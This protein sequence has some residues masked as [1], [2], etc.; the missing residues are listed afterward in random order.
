[1][2]KCFSELSDEELNF[3][4]RFLLNSGSLKEMAK[5]YEVSYP[6]LRLR[7]NRLIEKIEAIEKPEENDP[8]RLK[9]KNLAAEGEI[10]L[11]TAKKILSEYDKQKKEE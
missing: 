3:I 11:N 1:M 8:F 10:S 5:Q 7:L 4:K 9:I 2:L 6:T